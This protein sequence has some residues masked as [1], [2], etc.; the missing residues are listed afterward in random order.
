MKTILI[1]TFILMIYLLLLFVRE[2]FQGGLSG[3][4]SVGAPFIDLATY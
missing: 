4:I 3:G 2:H 1:L